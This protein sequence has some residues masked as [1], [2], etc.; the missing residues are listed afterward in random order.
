MIYLLKS[1]E[2]SENRGRNI[3]IISVFVLLAILSFVFP[4]TTRNIFTAVAKPIWNI[5]DDA[6]KTLGDIYTFLNLQK[7]LTAE[8]KNLRAEVDLLNLKVVDYDTLLQQ[9]ADL[10]SLLGRNVSS[11]Q[12]LARILSEPPESPYDSLVIDVGASDGV[13]L[14]DKIYL[15]DSIIVGSIAGISSRTS[16]VQMFSTGGQKT[17]SVLERTGAM[18]ELTGR[19]GANFSV[20]VPKEAD[21]L[22][23]DVF[24]YPGLSPAVLGSVY[25]IDTSSQSA[26]KTIFIRIPENVFQSKWVFVEKNSQ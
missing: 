4:K 25:Y 24:T 3:L 21:I 22:W 16:L 17:E 11:P 1:K 9:N 8:N 2:K 12:I 26:F 7:N 15:S 6:Q 19:G 18:Y 13:N 5:G 20:D 23:G 14:G 10:K